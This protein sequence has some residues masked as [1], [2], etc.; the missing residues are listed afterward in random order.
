LLLFSV[1]LA[2]G[3]ALQSY[4]GHYVLNTPALPEDAKATILL[5]AQDTCFAVSPIANADELARDL[6][7]STPGAD[8]TTLDPSVVTIAGRPFVR[9]EVKGSALSRIVLATDIRCRDFLKVPVQVIIGTHPAEIETG[10]VFDFKP[11]NP[12]K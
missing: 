2:S 12:K 9:V 4:A 10:L 11:G 6:A 8:G 5:A 3:V 1:A 7:R